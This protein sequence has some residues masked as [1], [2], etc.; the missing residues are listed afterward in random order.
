M[1]ILIIRNYPN[2]MD[3]QF[4]TYNIQEIGLAKALVRKGHIC[5]IVF[6]ADKEERIIDY[7]FEHDKHINVYYRKGKNILKNAIYNNLDFLIQQYDVIQPCEYN[8]YQSW[9]LAKKYPDK[10]VI[11]HGP[12]YS[13]FN[14][15]YNL[16]SKVFD[17]F[18]LKRYIKLGTRFIVKSNL[19]QKFLISKGIREENIKAVG[20]GVD[21]EALSTNKEKNIPDFIDTM[22]SFKDGLV[23]LYVGRL[24]ERRNIS[25]LFDILKKVSLMENNVHLFM[26]GNGNDE[27]VKKCMEY[28]DEIGVKQLIHIIDKMEQKYLS[29]VYTKADCFLLPTEY[30]I[31]GMVLLESMYFGAI[32]VTTENGGSN[33]LIENEKN[34]FIV[35]SKNP[36][37]W[38]HHICNIYNDKDLT[39]KIKLGA[40]NTIMN[41]FTWDVLSEKIIRVYESLK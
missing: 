22:E 16:M 19:A 35:R 5:D 33:M 26:I 14:K 28:A 25:L 41:F 27:Y 34:G 31:F 39:K 4:N 13:E 2:Y 36:T 30:E 18:F 20:V 10:T 24:E 38:A 40:H 32:T 1:K 7:V 37:E 9:V 17:I 8:Q 11:Y 29:L 6:W 23:L 12:Y 21:L 15:R 3:V